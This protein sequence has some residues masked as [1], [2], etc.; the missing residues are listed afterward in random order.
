M[1][2]N[3]L[4]VALL[5]TAV[6]GSASATDLKLTAKRPTPPLVGYDNGPFVAT[7]PAS[8][9]EGGLPSATA[10]TSVLGFE[11]ISQFDNAV[12]GVNLIPP[13]PVGAVGTR[14]YVQFVNGAMAVF[15]KA[16][17]SRQLLQSSTQFWTKAAQ[18]GSRG[19]P[20]VLFNKEANR[21]IVV[22]FGANTKDVNI[23]VSDTDDA[24]GLWKSTRFVG[25]AAPVA[26]LG[27]QADFP[28]LAIDRNAVYIGTN[29]FAQT[30]AGG[31][32]LFQ[33]TSLNIIPYASVFKP[34]GGKPSYTGMKRFTTKATST[35]KT[36]GY[37]IQ[38]VNS[39]ESST[40]GNIIAASLNDDSLVRYDI[41]GAGS[42]APVRTAST[43]AIGTGYNSNAAARQPGGYNGQPSRLIDSGD[44]RIGSSAWE[45]DGRIY[46]VHTIT[47]IG[48]DT[49]YIRYTVLDSLTNAV[50]DE[51]DIGGGGYDTYNGSIAVNEFGQ[52]VI[53]YNRSGSQAGEGV[54]SVMARVF[55]TGSDGRL[56]QVGD[57]LLLKQSLTDRYQNGANYGF[58]PVGRQRWGDYSAVSVDPIDPASFWITGQFA[59]EYNLDQFGHPGGTGASRWGT[60]IAN[61]RTAGTGTV[62]LGL[63]SLGGEGGNTPIIANVPQGV[64][65]PASWA[66]LI[67]GFGLTGAV[68]RRQRTLASA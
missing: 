44:D 11:G 43:I 18:T 9:P 63:A 49:T 61:I 40:T 30:V 64:P 48:T 57:E 46:S 59:R 28:T 1:N 32:Y 66:M 37:T 7:G 45:V 21:W 19:D 53:S 27:S 26:G 68:M 5:V 39:W 15:D 16:S 47:P 2:R 33:G 25:Y 20:R 50:L 22:A 6:G 58:A 13:D 35:D 12:L 54:I 55:E 67:L 38:G 41:L 29:N 56:L 31:S 14:Q 8:G 23:A 42:A 34:T 3:H 51:A 60:W 17:G 24:L 65:E 52:L 4:V 62:S 10:P 36:R